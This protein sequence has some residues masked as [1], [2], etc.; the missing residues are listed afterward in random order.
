MIPRDLANNPDVV[1][2][3]NGDGLL[4]PET[5][6]KYANLKRLEVRKAGALPDKDRIFVMGDIHGCIDEFNQLL[7]KIA[8]NPEKD[9][10]ILAGDLVAKGP[11]S[12]GVIRRAKEIGA[13]CVRGNHDDKV[14]RFKTYELENGMPASE[15]TDGDGFL[16]EGEEIAKPLKLNNYHLALANALS[17]E[18]YEY[19]SS[20][21][22]IYHFPTWEN[23]VV[24]HAGLDPN[25]DDLALQDPFYTMTMRVI[26]DDGEPTRK[27]RAGTAWYTLWNRA[28]LERTDAPM[29]VYYGHTAASG[30]TIQQF[31]YGLDTGCVY[32]RNLT[33]IEMKTKQTFSVPCNTYVDKEEKD[34]E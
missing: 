15:D 13:W 31:T 33:V 18:D 1:V 19:L 30:L 2:L 28:Q 26:D 29:H 3:R 5:V 25:I 16:P 9:L 34:D 11:D 24:V 21:P 10:I 32:G 22:G 7:E 27:K 4:E 20:C 6:S 12:I 14:I 17:L 23:S 8:F